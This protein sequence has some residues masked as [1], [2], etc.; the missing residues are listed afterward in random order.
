MEE[1]LNQVYYNNSLRDYIIVASVILLSIIILKTLKQLIVRRVR[2]I[3]S[4]TASTADDFIINSIDRFGLPI[5]LFGIIYWALNYL[6]LSDRAAHVIDTATSIIVTYFIL[7]LVS[8][9][10]RSNN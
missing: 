10:K 6:T 2:A 8:V 4:K 1:I 5:I 9:K 7:R 3:A